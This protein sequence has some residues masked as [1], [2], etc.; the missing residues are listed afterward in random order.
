MLYWIFSSYDEFSNS[1]FAACS[2]TGFP[3]LSLPARM[4]SERLPVLCCRPRVAS[5]TLTALSPLREEHTVE[6]G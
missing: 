2:A 6:R 4:L 1:C 5:G 3:L